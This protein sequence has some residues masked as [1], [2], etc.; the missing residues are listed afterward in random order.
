MNENRHSMNK[1]GVWDANLKELSLIQ[2]GQKAHDMVKQDQI[3][4]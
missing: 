4:K 3:Y 2:S 1:N